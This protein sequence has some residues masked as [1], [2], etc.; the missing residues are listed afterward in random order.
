MP[1]AGRVRGAPT[2]LLARVSATAG[3]SRACAAG[4]CVPA[5]ARAVDRAAAR[6][7]RRGVPAARSAA[8]SAASAR[9]P[10]TR[11][12]S[13]R[14]GCCA[15]PVWSRSTPPRSC[16]RRCSRPAIRA[17]WPASSGTAVGGRFRHRCPWGSCS[18]R[19]PRR[20]V[21][22]AGDRRAPRAPRFRPPAPRRPRQSS[23][24]RPVA[25]ARA[26]RRR[27]VGARSSRLIVVV[28][29]AAS[30]RRV[31][32]GQPPT[33]RTNVEQDPRWGERACR[34]RHRG[35]NLI[36]VRRSRPRTRASAPRSRC[37]TSCS[38]TAWRCRPRRAV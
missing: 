7:R 11:S 8:R 1:A 18:P 16:S 26:G 22:A 23:A 5:F 20:A 33:R 13:P 30:V 35:G 37:R 32:S 12:R 2:A 15:P 14:C 25:R 28:S 31:L 17:G 21:G 3:R 36:A 24:R 10:V 29:A 6:A 34:A 9:Y 38:S 19:V 4:T 27:L